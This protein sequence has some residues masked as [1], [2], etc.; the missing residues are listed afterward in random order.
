MKLTDEEQRMLEGKYGKAV[1]M[2]MSI[3]TKLGEIYDAKK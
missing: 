1:S 2:A 3:L